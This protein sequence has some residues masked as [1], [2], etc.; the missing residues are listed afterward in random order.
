MHFTYILNIDI[1]AIFC[2]HRI[3]IVSKLK[4]LYRTITTDGTSQALRRRRRTAP[5]RMDTCCGGGCVTEEIVDRTGLRGRR[6]F[7]VS[8]CKHVDQPD[9]D[10]VQ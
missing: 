4:K 10:G 9:G 1:I 7:I 6:L 2:K 3:D 8:C 5:V